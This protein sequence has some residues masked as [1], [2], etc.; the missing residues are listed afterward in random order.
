[1]EQ[2]SFWANVFKKKEAEKTSFL[3]LKNVPIFKDLSVRELQEVDRITH[4]RTYEGGERVFNEGDPGVGMY[5]IQNGTVRIVKEVEGEEDQELALLV[6]GSFFGELALLDESPRSAT[7]V[8]KEASKIIGFFRP[9]F[10]SLMERRPRIGLKIMR[11]LAE[12]IGQR[13]R[14]TN[15]ELQRQ[16][17]QVEETTKSEAK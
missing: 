3:I 4:H 2:N 14:A 17:S 13:L 5:I 9:D 15:Q 7:A 1:M 12:V 8:A 11:N 6:S 16:Q 10:L